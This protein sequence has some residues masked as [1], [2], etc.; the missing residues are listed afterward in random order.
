MGEYVVDVKLRELKRQMSFIQQKLEY[1]RK[2]RDLHH[3]QRIDKTSVPRTKK[4][5]KSFQ[6]PRILLS[7]FWCFWSINNTHMGFLLALSLFCSTCFVT[8]NSIILT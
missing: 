1:A 8:D 2:K 3:P 4:S 6:S 5:K 7:C